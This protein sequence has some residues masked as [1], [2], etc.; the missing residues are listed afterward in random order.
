MTLPTPHNNLFTFTLSH[1]SAARS[2]IET[3]FPGA[4]VEQLDLDSMVIESG[5]FIDPS[6]AEKFS[7]VLLS[8]KTK[9]SAEGSQQRVL[10]YFLFEHKSEPDSLTVLQLLS[11]V[12]RIWEREVREG[13]PLSPILPMVI[14]H[15]DRPWNVSMSIDELIDCPDS[16]RDYLVK[17]TCPVF[18]LT[19]SNDESISDDPFL[20]SMF[21]LLKYGRTDELVE[22]LRAILEILKGVHPSLV[23]DWILAIGV[24]VMSVNKSITQEE[25]AETVRSVW[26]VQIESGS[27]ADKLLEKGREE[28]I[29]IGE[30]RGEARGII[31]T[32]QGILGIAMDDDEALREKSMEELNATVALLRAKTLN[33][34]NGNE[35]I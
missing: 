9:L 26:P 5:S 16:M 18:D 35:Q 11:Y 7:D 28:G 27:L 8:V 34:A 33:R 32:L 10:A 6:L 3:R 17:F 30:A 23:E 22:R 29:E 2:L 15:G 24:Y 21:Q 12:I 1:I 25:F 19:R 31:K 14:Y 13:R 20:Q 4:I